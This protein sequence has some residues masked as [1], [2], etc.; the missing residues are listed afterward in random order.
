MLG[1]E[2]G[3]IPTQTE[4]PTLQ[5]PR[6]KMYIANVSNQTTV[7]YTKFRVEGIVDGMNLL[8]QK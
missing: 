3:G 8:R 7:H 1:G 6:T 4:T 5:Y 2:T